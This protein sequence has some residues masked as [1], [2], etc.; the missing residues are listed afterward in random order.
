MRRLPASVEVG[1]IA[2]KARTD[3]DAILDIIEILNDPDLADQ[4]R[5]FLA[6][7]YF[8]ENWEDI[9][10]DDYQEAIEKL[11]WFINGGK[12]QTETAPRPKLVDWEQDWDL[13]VPPI[14]KVLG[15]EIRAGAPIHWWTFLSAYME[16]GECTFSTVVSIRDKQARGKPLDKSEKEWYRRNRDI[17][18]LE[19]RYTMEEKD[20]LREWGGG[21]DV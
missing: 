15:R 5:A 6:I 18:D 21:T 19:H 9:P 3:Y 8:Y 17:V 11:F 2:Q 20:F 4:E 13:I 14:N 12:I 10:Q 16:I 1:G 7:M